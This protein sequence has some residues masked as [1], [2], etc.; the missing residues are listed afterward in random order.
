MALGT[1]DK[2]TRNSLPGQEPFVPTQDSPVLSSGM[3]PRPFRGML[4][5]SLNPLLDVWLGECEK[6]FAP[7]DLEACD[8]T[9]NAW[10]SNGLALYGSSESTR[11]ESSAFSRFL[12]P[13]DPTAVCSLRVIMALFTIR[14]TPDSKC[15]LP[16]GSVRWKPLSSFAFPKSLINKN[17]QLPFNIAHDR[18][19][20]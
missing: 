13:I 4:T 20:L 19:I 17:V 2:S 12:A 6:F 9:L 14:Q 1:M 3:E 18:P 10:E 15:P 7:H 11:S 5:A 16:D 8:F